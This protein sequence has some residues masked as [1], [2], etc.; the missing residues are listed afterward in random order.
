MILQIAASLDM[1]L[2]GG[3][4]KSAFMQGGAD[5]TGDQLYLRPPR[6]GTLPGVHPRQLLKLVGSGYGKVNAPRLWYRQFAGFLIKDRWERHSMD[7]TVFLL[8][9]DWLGNLQLVGILGM[10]VDDVLGGV[11]DEK[12]IKPLN[13]RFQL[14]SVQ[15][16]DL[17]FCGRHV[18][19]RK[20]T[21]EIDMGSYCMAIGTNKLVGGGGDKRCLHF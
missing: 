13:D 3:D 21:I 18:T 8:Y 11:V 17:V 9:R 19:Q 5:E 15:W 20:N 16:N 1:Q 12:L 6:N 4:A 2:F 10:H 14:G 7:P